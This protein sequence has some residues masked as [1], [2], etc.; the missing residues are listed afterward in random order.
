MLNETLVVCTFSVT[1]NGITAGCASSV[2]FHDAVYQ[3]NHVG[4][5]NF[6]R[7]A[8]SNYNLYIEGLL[9]DDRLSKM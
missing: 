2:V 8:R 1:L 9:K 4:A 6:M 5:F 7:N 3:T